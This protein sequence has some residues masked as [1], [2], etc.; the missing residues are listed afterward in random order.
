MAEGFISATSTQ[1]SRYAIYEVARSYIDQ[2]IG[3]CVLESSEV[4]RDGRIK[5]CKI[6]DLLHELAM[7][8]SH[9][10]LNVC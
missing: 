10:E 6:H 2:L 8:E 3:R 5:Y 4:G 9:K 1:E 7:V